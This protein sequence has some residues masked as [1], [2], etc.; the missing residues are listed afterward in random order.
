[1]KV[2]PWWHGVAVIL[3]LTLVYVFVSIGLEMVKSIN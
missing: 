1:M 3:W 2:N